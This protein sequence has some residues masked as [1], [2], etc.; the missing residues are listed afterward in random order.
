MSKSRAIANTIRKSETF[1]NFT[2]RQRDLWHG[3][4]SI[5]DDQGRMP[6][7]P[8]FI[9]SQVWPYDDISEGEILTDLETIAKAGNI[10]CYEADNRKYIQII[11]WWKYQKG[12]WFS[13]S[14]YPAPEGWVDRWRFHVKGNVIE[15]H[16]WTSPGGF[17][18]HPT[19]Q[20]PSE[21]PST[22]PSE[23]PSQLP[24]PLPARDDDDDVKGS[25][26][27]D[28]KVDGEVAPNGAPPTSQKQ[29]RTTEEIIQGI[30]TSHQKGLL[31]I[32]AIHD[33]LLEC[34]NIEPDLDTPQG[35]KYRTWRKKRPE[36]ET[37]RRFAAWW[38]E[39]DWRGKKRNP[40]ELV[41]IMEL[42]PQAFLEKPDEYAGARE[43]H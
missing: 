11:N 22:L 14:D 23:L 6:A 31:E 29:P 3:L 20:L 26:E 36:Y 39:F 2:Y 40:P 30:K 9:R 42:W 16:N 41:Q 4:I 18:D 12:E 1:A 24:P 17:V 8:R 34:F 21:L 35:R 10:I 13:K 33:E 43:I 19:S 7:N 25:G 28:D 27:V 37:M 32:Q 15:T 38:Y 5:A